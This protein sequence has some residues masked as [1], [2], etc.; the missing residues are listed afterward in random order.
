MV[1]PALAPFPEGVEHV[2]ERGALLGTV[3]P[4][5]GIVRK[6]M[7]DRAT[8]EH[9]VAIALGKEGALLPYLDVYKR[10]GRPNDKSTAA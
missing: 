1:H 2:E 6:R 9:P 10:Q 7:I 8:N 3:N 5:C 4:K